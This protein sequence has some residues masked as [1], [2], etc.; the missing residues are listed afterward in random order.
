L[1]LL[2]AEGAFREDLYYRISEIVVDLPP[3]RD[4]EGDISVLAH[5][6][7]EKCSAEQGKPKR[8]FSAE[9]IY[10]MERYAWPGNVRELENKIKTAVI[11]AEGNM[12]GPGDLGL[13]ANGET[14]D[15]GLLLNLKTVRG[16][17]ELAALQKALAITD[18]NISRSAELLGITRPTLYDLME[19]HGLGR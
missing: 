14:D 5:L 19:R 4:R 1:Q 15:D 9:A 10:A 18:R 3:L 8:G 12:I 6:L 2:I 7:M 16:Q 17:A 13:V 11:M